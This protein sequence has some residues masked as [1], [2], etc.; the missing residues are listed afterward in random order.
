MSL[1][2]A[3]SPSFT[4]RR[5]S[6]GT[7]LI[8][9][10]AMLWATVGVASQLSPALAS[11][12]PAFTGAIRTALGASLL[13]CIASLRGTFSLPAL[14]TLLVFGTAGA[15]FQM[16][17][18][19]GFALA[20][21]TLTVAVTVCLP[22]VLIALW[23]C[24]TGRGA[25]LGRLCP[26]L[27]LSLAGVLTMLAPTA[28]GVSPKAAAML[29]VAS[30]AFA[31]IAV[32]ARALCAGRDSCSSVGLG[33]AV[34]ALLLTGVTLSKGTVSH[35]PLDVAGYAILA[36]LGIAATG[37]AY[38]AFSAGMRR[39]PSLTAGMIATLLE[40]AM[41][42]LLASLILAESLSGREAIGALAVLAGLVLSTRTA[43]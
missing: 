41:A 14:Q 18:F 5:S 16:T 31:V 43:R 29:L 9:L 10:A 15:V 33:L 40:P 12:D 4:Y 24:A 8:C 37:G 2:A 39:A 25:A 28:N 21:V 11:A 23:D 42:A 19:S 3:H 36:Y 20:G 17:L 1:A 34:T 27:L 30:I 26:A 32:S 22:P 35:L 6:N 13:L 7:G 38:L